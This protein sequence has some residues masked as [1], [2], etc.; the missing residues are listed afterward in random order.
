VAGHRDM[1]EQIARA[2]DERLTA[3][4]QSFLAALADADGLQSPARLSLIAKL[5]SA[6]PVIEEI[7]LWNSPDNP[8]PGLVGVQL[9]P[10]SNAR[11]PAPEPP[12][13]SWLA[14][15]KAGEE[16]EFQKQNHEEALTHYQL[17]LAE[18]GNASLRGEALMA[19]ARVQRKSNRLAEALKTYQTVAQDHHEA[20]TASGLSLGLAA[21]REIGGLLREGL[22][23]S[24]SS[25]IAVPRGEPITSPDHRALPERCALRFGGLEYWICLPRQRTPAERSRE[26]RWGYLLH[27]GRFQALL[28]RPVIEKYAAASDAAW[29]VL[30]Q[31]G[32]TVLKAARAAGGPI[33]VRQSF[34]GGVPPWELQFHQ[35]TSGFYETLLTSRRGVYLYAFVLLAGILVF[36]L[37]L[38]SRS[39]TRELELA[40]LK[41]DFVSTVS[42]EFK[43]P[44]TAIRQL[45]EMLQAGRVPSEPRRQEYYG[46]LVEQSERLTRLIDNILDFARLEE[47][48]KPFTLEVVAPGELL[49]PLAADFQR[50][51][52]HAGFILESRIA[53]SL[54]EV[55]A[56]RA[57]LSQAVS[58]LLDN[59]FKYSGDSR[60]IILSAFAEPRQIV[61]A[62]QDFGLGIRKDELDRVFDRFYRSGDAST[63]S[64]KGTGMGLT[65]V[66]RI[67]DAH[68]GTV[69]VVSELGCGSTFSIRLPASASKP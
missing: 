12:P 59:A 6:H 34:A 44:L 1:G 55:S 42:H 52:G 10:D 69:R 29:V 60:R 3:V 41:S 25:E 65:L 40:R 54:P 48:R 35:T 45:A 66:K 49:S 18:G 62:V 9:P 11:G 43:S 23:R 5:K 36:G 27:A 20:W 53:E 57:A 56:D 4:D 31:Q 63:R 47:G 51:V 13:V 30:G 24:R 58:N 61:I 39:I 33:S 2:L 28:L 7:F 32:E 21:R 22:T 67:I 8:R 19:I 26:P 38:T 14:R 64:V 68:N 46:V 16:L 37:A 17:C 50:R 15:R